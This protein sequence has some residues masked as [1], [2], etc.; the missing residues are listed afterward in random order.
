MFLKEIL[1]GLFK[2]SV[3]WLLSIF[4]L[5]YLVICGGAVTTVI[6][7]GEKF[8]I[9]KIYNGDISH[10]CFILRSTLYK[11]HAVFT[12]VNCTCNNEKSLSYSLKTGENTCTNILKCPQEL[13]LP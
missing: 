11:K 13:I 4:S 2:V 5:R 1:F 3:K 10:N 9:E 7:P 8:E 12:I 6:R